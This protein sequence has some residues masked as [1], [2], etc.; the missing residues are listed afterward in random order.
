MMNW[1]A[2]LIDLSPGRTRQLIFI[3]LSFALMVTG[4]LIMAT[5]VVTGMALMLVGYYILLRNSVIARRM[6]ARFKRRYP[7][8]F[9]GFDNWRHRRA[10]R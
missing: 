1:I 6:F 2:D 5:P 7:L 10:R 4:I 3:G 9:R 8:S